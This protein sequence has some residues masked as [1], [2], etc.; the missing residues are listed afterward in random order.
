MLELIPSTRPDGALILHCG[1]CDR[2]AFVDG[3]HGKYLCPK[4]GDIVFLPQAVAVT[5]SPAAKVEIE[6]AF[7]EVP[8]IADTDGVLTAPGMV[9]L[10]LLDEEP[11]QDATADAEAEEP[12]EA[13][14]AVPV[15]KNGKPLTGALLKRWREKR[16]G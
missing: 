1:R 4:C 16:G 12:S 5:K 6:L 9:A 13:P 7:V 8:G 2:R 14:P 10:P 15:D 11:E 3:G